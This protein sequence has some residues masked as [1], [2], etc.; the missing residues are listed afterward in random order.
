MLQP[1]EGDP[2]KVPFLANTLATGSLLPLTSLNNPPHFE[3]I[4]FQLEEAFERLV[5][6]P[7]AKTNKCAGCGDISHYKRDCITLHC[8]CTKKKCKVRKD[9][10]NYHTG[11]CR[12]GPLDIWAGY[13][14]TWSGAAIYGEYEFDGVNSTDQ[15]SGE[16]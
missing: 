5:Q 16:A 14:A 12:H 3:T 4:Q 15:I 7:R 10:K 6:D 2:A 9:H 11:P 8:L 1:F 13:E